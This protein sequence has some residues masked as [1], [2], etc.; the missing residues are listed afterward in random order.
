MVLY[1]RQLGVFIRV[2]GIERNSNSVQKANELI[3]GYNLREHFKVIEQDI[4]LL[5]IDDVK[6]N[7]VDIVYTILDTTPEIMWKLHL[8]SIAASTVQAMI[9]SEEA[10]SYLHTIPRGTTSITRDTLDFYPSRKAPKVITKFCENCEL[11]SDRDH[12]VDD[13]DLLKRPLRSMMY[14]DDMH[15]STYLDIVCNTARVYMME[16]A[17]KRATVNVGEANT[18][19]LAP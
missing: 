3:D 10:M 17:L 11:A 5:D 8:I 12:H 13:P 15:H 18:N 2:L 14:T 4:L 9:A 6:R 1:F 7:K 19:I 16:G